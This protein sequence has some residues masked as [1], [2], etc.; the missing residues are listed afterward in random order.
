M[1]VHYVRVGDG[2]AVDSWNKAEAGRSKAKYFLDRRCTTFW[3]V[4]LLCMQPLA[5]IATITAIVPANDCSVTSFGALCDG[6]TDDTH[7]IQTALASC[8]TNQRRTTIP[9]KKTCLSQPL[10]LYSNTWLHLLSNATLKAGQRWNDTAFISTS[11][12]NNITL[13][14]D[15]GGTIDG[16]GKQ[17]W[18]GSN[19]TPGRPP[20][21]VLKDCVRVLIQGVTIINPPAWTTDLS[22]RDY[23]IYNVHIKSPPYSVAPNTDGIDLAVDGAHV[24]GC[25]IENGDDSICMK[26]PCHNILVEDS[27]VRQGNGFVIGTSSNANFSN[28]T[29][30][31][32]VAE[33]TM[34]G[35]HIKFKNNQTGHAKDI[36]FEDITIKN[37]VLYAL[38]INQNGQLL[39][40]Y[41]EEETDDNDNNDDNVRSS[42]LISNITF[43]NI[44]SSGGLVAG[45]FTC[46]PGELACEKILMENVTLANTAGNVGC[47][48]TNTFGNG[49]DVIPKSCIPPTK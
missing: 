19:K 11:N 49:A 48:F 4:V 30:R 2:R 7:S 18:T 34:Y 12:A 42:V 20:L 13:T 23:K 3:I 8:T 22:G 46:N 26:S 17:W 36:L 1:S 16:S 37:P 44:V 45:Y 9:S 5:A 15:Q 40:A 41:E 38:G 24:K 28:I 31:N 27:I 39:T 6:V 10:I 14:A 43:R 35:C 21:L 25:V 29:F 47:S 33:K 32:S